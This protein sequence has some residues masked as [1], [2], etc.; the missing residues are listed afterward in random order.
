MAFDKMGYVVKCVGSEVWSDYRENNGIK[1]RFLKY[2]GLYIVKGDNGW[3]LNAKTA[4]DA[5]IFQT[6]EKAEECRKKMQEAFNGLA[7]FR[8]QVLLDSFKRVR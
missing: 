1:E 4:K 6:I 5:H 8:V 3:K 7:H 2:N